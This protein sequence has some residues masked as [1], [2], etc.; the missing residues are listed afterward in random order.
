MGTSC[1]T[2]I[3][4]TI[5]TSMATKSSTRV[6]PVCFMGFFRIWSGILFLSLLADRLPIS[7]GVGFPDL[8][9]AGG[10]Q[11]HSS[12][13]DAGII[14]VAEIERVNLRRGGIHGAAAIKR[15]GAVGQRDGGEGGDTHCGG[16]ACP[17]GRRG[18]R[19]EVYGAAELKL[20]FTRCPHPTPTGR[21]R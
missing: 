7:E 17:T 4:P 6:K 10:Q 8:H 19:D 14:Q 9:G 2:A 15:D 16:P 13:A 1:A 20:V 12:R 11:D 21:Q 3:K 5:S 18:S